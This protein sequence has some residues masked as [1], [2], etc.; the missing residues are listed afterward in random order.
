VFLADAFIQSDLESLQGIH[1]NPMTLVVPSL[2]K[3]NENT[4]SFDSAKKKNIAKPAQVN[5]VRAM[6]S[7]L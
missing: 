5:L 3:E 4:V 2:G 1:L 7:H 6:S